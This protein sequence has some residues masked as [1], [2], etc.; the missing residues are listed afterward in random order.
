MNLFGRFDV[1]IHPEGVIRIP[2]VLG[3]NQPVPDFS[4]IGLPDPAIQ[5]A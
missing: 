2:F 1:L 4:R 5:C 3:F